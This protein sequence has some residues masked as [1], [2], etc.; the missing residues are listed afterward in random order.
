M[1]KDPLVNSHTQVYVVIKT[2][3]ARLPDELTIR[4]GELVD[5]ISD[6]SEFDDGWYMGKNLTTGEV[7]LYPKVFTKIK[8][9]TNTYRNSSKTDSDS[10]PS[11]KPSLLRSRSRKTPQSG[12]S[13]ISTPTY[14]THFNLNNVPLPT[15]INPQSNN[16]NIDNPSSNIYHHE[17]ISNPN[18]VNRYVNDID[19]ALNE[20]KLD[21]KG[22]SFSTPNMNQ[23]FV[24]FSD[25]PLNPGNVSNWT[26][27]QVSQYFSTIVEPQIAQKFITHQISG[28]ILLELELAYLKELDISSFGTRF[29]IYKEIE[30]L[31]EISSQ[32]QFSSQP[33]N[34]DF[35][36][37]MGEHA[38]NSN[39]SNI[40]SPQN[41]NIMDPSIHRLSGTTRNFSQSTSNSDLNMINEFNSSNGSVPSIKIK[42]NTGG[43]G[44]TGSK[45]FSY[46]QALRPQSVIFD[47][48]SHISKTSSL[49]HSN[50]SN[51]Y[52]YHSQT[53]LQ[54]VYEEPSLDDVPMGISSS[55][56][57]TENNENNNDISLNS[58]EQFISPRR[59][60]KP[61]NYPSP[62]SNNPIKFGI[63]PSAE[64]P[65][66]ALPRLPQTANSRRSS[67]GN[68]SS[69]YIDTSPIAYSKGH[70]KNNSEISNLDVSRNTRRNSEMLHVNNDK[71]TTKESANTSSIPSS[72]N[73]NTN[74]SPTIGK[75][76]GDRRSVSAKEFPNIMK[77]KELPKRV[78]SD[79]ATAAAA[80]ALG[81][82]SNPASPKI[83]SPTDSSV[84]S[85]TLSTPAP[86][87]TA[88]TANTT[89][90]T[91]LR[92]KVTLRS[93]K[94]QTSAFQE[95][96]RSITPT[97]AK[98]DADCSGWM[99]KR[100]NLS[101]GSWKHRYFTLHK[102]R[103]SYYT[104]TSDTKEKG[105]IDITSHRVLPAT[106]AEDKLSAVYAA[107]AG[108]GRYCFKLVPPAPGSR[109]GLTFTQQKVH[110]FAVETREEMRTWMSALMRATIELDETVPAISSCV[111]PTI[112]LQKAQEMMAV[113]R[114]NA[115]ENFDTLQ[116]IREDA[117]ATNATNN[118]R[119]KFED[120]K[121][122]YVGSSH[123]NSS[124]EEEDHSQ[125]ITSRLLGS[126]DTPSSTES[127]S[128]N[129]PKR[130]TSGS[131]SGKHSPLNGMSTPYLVTSGM[132]SPNVSGFSGGSGD[133]PARMGSTKFHA[134]TVTRLDD[135]EITV[136]PTPPPPP[137]HSNSHSFS[138][139]M[140]SLRKVKD[141]D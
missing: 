72:A 53:E 90:K 45:R 104:S 97:E 48:S 26:P 60:P 98:K 41:P 95:G 69:I 127:L 125:L 64:E 71:S 140:M 23:Q 25:D 132:I 27:E 39:G 79:A 58:T 128:I 76:P 93:N 92:H 117:Y 19:Q 3:E 131:T 108:Y 116:K 63:K 44:T 15:D 139:R 14:Q 8:K 56:K 52:T 68:A 110:Y 119:E 112:P 16:N 17:N 18:G 138:R 28:R 11:S 73:G 121:N 77:P 81:G 35:N 130:A 99:F 31:K 1:N 129:K 85:P 113:A 94:M 20:L 12:N 123:E 42:S 136:Q 37:A 32:F 34:Q 83:D 75:Q 55:I 9:D 101:I 126:D 106:E 74:K 30:N 84:S 59:A 122:A 29:T 118:N 87:P 70:S 107:T 96:I 120:P 80:I 6:D 102:T 89:P 100:G 43:I 5:L 109:K 40:Y 66:L 141:R 115:K 2:F 50:I 7:G 78:Q 21:N 46:N 57:T 134:P 137:V 103:L 105:L 124:V 47:H 67:V 49:P 135:D 62:V 24:D 91:T 33:P 82:N 36:L 88:A 65:F 133:T 51:D 4:E 22:S 61:P 13:P 86:T 111:T 38:N 10:T 114:E 54:D